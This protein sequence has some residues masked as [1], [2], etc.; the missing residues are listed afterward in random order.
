MTNRMPQTPSQT[1]GPYFAYGLTARQ[2]GYDWDQLADGRI[3]RDDTPGPRIRVFGQVFD[4][5]GAPVDDAMIEIWQADAS[6]RYPDE[7][8]FADRG[9]FHGVGRCGTGA[10]P[11]LRF[12]FDTIK[13]GGHDGEAPHLNV[14]VMMRGLLLHAY[15]RI[16][17]ADEEEAN[18][19]DPVLALVPEERRGTLVARALGGG[20]Y[21]FD[22]AMQG[23][24]ETVFF[25]V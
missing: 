7:A 9:A 15:T 8:D 24:D 22:I 5:A 14:C 4:G 16:Y 12:V 2:Y 19:A 25:D 6:G 10:D 1:V 18:A 17:F 20:L 3:A 13:P 21:H 11:S 23:D